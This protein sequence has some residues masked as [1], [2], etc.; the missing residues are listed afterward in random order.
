[1]KFSHTLTTQAT[2]AAIWAV[3]VNVAEWP[4]W[5][6]ELEQ[7][8]LDGPFTLGAVGTLKP[9]TGPRARFTISTLVPGTSYMFTTKLPLCSLH[10]QRT[11]RQNDT[12][13]LFTHDVWFD[14]PLAGLFG[15]V[16]GQR[17]RRVLPHAM[18]RLRQRAES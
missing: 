1:M 17:Y 2:G 9:R 13:T 16:L 15:I 14:G 5:D 6:T 8:A 3:W 18:V 10:V 4:S 12:E 11:L 7:A